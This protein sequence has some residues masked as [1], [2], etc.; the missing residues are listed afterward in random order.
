MVQLKIAVL[1][2]EE[3]YL[4]QLKGYFVCKN[5]KFFKIWTF[6][7][8][9]IF[10]DKAEEERNGCVDYFFKC[11]DRAAHC[12]ALFLSE[13]AGHEGMVCSVAGGGGAAACAGVLF[14]EQSERNESF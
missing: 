6:S 1:D 14:G 10:L 3:A 12:P 5:E 11:I 13:E 2:E 9:E 4:E 7:K 8:V